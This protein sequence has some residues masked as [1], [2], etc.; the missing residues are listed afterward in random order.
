MLCAVLCIDDMIRIVKTLP[1][2]SRG[3]DGNVE[4]TPPERKD[5]CAAFRPE[6][7]TVWREHFAGRYNPVK[8]LAQKYDNIHLAIMGHKLDRLPNDPIT[9][10]RVGSAGETRAV[11]TS[12]RKEMAV[13][14]SGRAG[15][16]RLWTYAPDASRAM[17][18]VAG[19]LVEL[20]PA[21][22]EAEEAVAAE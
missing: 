7:G 5:R 22:E 1:R 12:L 10:S 3:T 2:K 16:C 4:D 15:V 20:V 18:L 6:A 8:R 17:A 14:S 11:T 9:V 21:A 13:L 19:E